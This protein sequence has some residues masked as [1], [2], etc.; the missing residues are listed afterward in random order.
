M[1]TSSLYVSP[2]AQPLAGDK[3]LKRS[4]KLVKKSAKDKTLK[5]GVKEV[6]KFV[7]KGNKGV[8]VLAGD[9]D[10][11]DVISHMPV[12]LEDN[13]IPYV[14]VPSKAELGSS[15]LSKR[16]VSCVMVPVNKEAEYHSTYEKVESEIGELPSVL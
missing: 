13:N 10:P 4:L 2:I 14:Y 9:V 16:A 5:R 3:L 8:C 6:I 12:F 1:S 7:K 15:G 11:I